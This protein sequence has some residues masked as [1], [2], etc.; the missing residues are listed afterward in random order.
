MSFLFDRKNDKSHAV[1]KFKQSKVFTCAP[2]KSFFFG[3]RSTLSQSQFSD[4]NAVQT[5]K[6]REKRSWHDDEKEKEK[7]RI[8][9][10]ENS[11]WT[12]FLSSAFAVCLFFSTF[13]PEHF[14]PKRFHSIVVC[15]SLF[16]LSI[17]VVDIFCSFFP[18][19][20][21][22]S[23]HFHLV[24]SHCHGCRRFFTLLRISTA[25]QFNKCVFVRQRKATE[26]NDAQVVAIHS[27]L[28]CK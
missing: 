15:F 10:H 23:L 24:V 2:H 14:N 11:S 17:F 26:K 8:W 3:W 25:F 9:A 19:T 7:R 12:S 13:Q 6:R 27:S 22:H 1:Q 21:F 16:L 20:N 4:L 5:Q 18:T 28:N